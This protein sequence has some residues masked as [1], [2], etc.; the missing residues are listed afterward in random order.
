MCLLLALEKIF[1]Q[2]LNNFVALLHCFYLKGHSCE[3]ADDMSCFSEN[4]LRCCMV[5]S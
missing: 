5:K 2:K 4:F 1:F 3:V